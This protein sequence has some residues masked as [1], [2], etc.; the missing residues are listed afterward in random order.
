MANIYKQHNTQFLASE[1]ASY[2]K[3]ADLRGISVAEWI[4][5]AC[6]QALADGL[7]DT[8]VSP[9]QASEFQMGRRTEYEYFP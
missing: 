3:A 4:R 1:F 7:K 9:R 6:K 2:K 5:R 8:S